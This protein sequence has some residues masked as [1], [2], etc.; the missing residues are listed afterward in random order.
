MV[1]TDNMKL[2]LKYVTRAI[3]NCDHLLL[4]L[5]ITFFLPLSNSLLT[6]CFDGTLGGHSLVFLLHVW[7]RTEKGMRDGRSLISHRRQTCENYFN[8]YENFMYILQFFYIR[9]YALCNLFDVT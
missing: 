2:S 7:M 9:V 3:G 5:V 8:Y 4:K 1:V 6:A